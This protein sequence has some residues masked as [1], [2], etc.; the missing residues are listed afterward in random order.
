MLGTV[1]GAAVAFM[2]SLA[3]GLNGSLS[4]SL[5]GEGTVAA[6]GTTVSGTGSTCSASESPTPS[7][8]P[9]FFDPRK[10]ERHW[11]PP[12]LRGDVPTNDSETVLIIAAGITRGT[13]LV[14][15][16]DQPFPFVVMTKG[17]PPGT[18]NSLPANVGR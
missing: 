8:S 18:P 1:V 2:L 10:S 14:W 11:K 5:G 12:S 4:P 9:S 16:L 7:P 3:T 6:S 15:L 13:N 17:E